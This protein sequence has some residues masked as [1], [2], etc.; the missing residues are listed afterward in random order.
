MTWLEITFWI[1]QGLFDLFALFVLSLLVLAHSALD[2]R[3][4]AQ[5]NGLFAVAKNVDD[6]FRWTN[7]NVREMAKFI[8]QAFNTELVWDKEE[9]PQSSPPPDNLKN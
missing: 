3:S 5:V 1:L 6:R 8:A 9:P 4:K 7:S 2:K